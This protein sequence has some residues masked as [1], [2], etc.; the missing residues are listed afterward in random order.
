[1]GTQYVGQEAASVIDRNVA[2]RKEVYDPL[3]RELANT[4][5]DTSMITDANKLVAKGF[6]NTD[7]VSERS[8]SRYGVQMDG[9]AQRN[10]E[11]AK[12]LAHGVQR[13]NIVNNAISKQYDRNQQVTM[14]LSDIGRGVQSTATSG[15]V[16]GASNQ[17]QIAQAEANA[18]AAKTAQK[19]QM[20]GMAAAMAIAFM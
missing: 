7:A 20:M 19:N 2:N 6:A 11:Q 18:D 14:A 10:Y 13:S 15:F 9:A 1:M 16:Q 17:A 4:L 3:A 12:N 5:N 8:L